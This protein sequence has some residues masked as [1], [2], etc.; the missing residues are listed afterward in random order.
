MSQL[1]PFVKRF[2]TSADL[3]RLLQSRGLVVDDVAKAEHYLDTIGYYRLSALHAPIAECAK[4][5]AS[6]QGRVFVQT[7]DDALSV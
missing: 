7:G 2:K 5:C 1:T 3:I 6:V 4:V